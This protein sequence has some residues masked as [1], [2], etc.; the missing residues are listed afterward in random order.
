MGV[1]KWPTQACTI[2]YDTRGITQ[3][4]TSQA[5]LDVTGCH[6]QASACIASS[7]RRLPWMTVLVENAKHYQKTTLARELTVDC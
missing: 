7:Q 3:W 4:S 2:P 5:S 6:H 1:T